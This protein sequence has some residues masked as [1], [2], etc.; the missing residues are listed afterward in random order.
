M[1]PTRLDMLM[2]LPFVLRRWG[3]ASLQ[4]AKMLTRFSS[5]RSRKSCTEKSSIGL[6]GGCQPALLIRQSMRPCFCDGAVDEGAD[7]V[8]LG[9]VAANEVRACPG[10]ARVDLGL[11]RLALGRVA[12]AEHDVGAAFFN[13]H[14][15]A[16]QADALAAA[17]DD[18]D[19]VLVPHAAPPVPEA[20]Q[21]DGGDDDGAGDDLLH[22]VGPAHLRAA[23]LDDLHGERADQAA[24]HGAFAAREAAAA[25][26]D[27]GD[28]VQLEA[29]GAGRIADRQPRE[30]HQAG[31]AREQAAQHVDRQLTRATGTPHRRAACSFEPTANTWRPRRVYSSSAP[32][33]AA[34][35]NSSHTPG[36]NTIHS[37]SASGRRGQ[38]LVQPRLGRVDLLVARD[39]LGDA[40]H[41]QHRPQ[42]DDERHDLEPRHQEAV[43]R[44]AADA[45]RDARQRGGRGRRAG[46]QAGGDDDGGERDDRA[47]PRDRCRPTR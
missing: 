33:A 6:W 47:R 15:N 45:G 2:M 41:Q 34:N 21:R 30:L 27:G 29:D 11:D 23:R 1:A 46:A 39:A 40:A 5:S 8:D 44:A 20:I 12:R 25:D 9:D 22:P 28:D 3:R 31:D 37:A 24:E 10:A 18:D 26:H 4:A 32:T 19:L 36:G 7:V 13:E 38:Q 14:L 42:R 16:A 43:E 17:G 35:R